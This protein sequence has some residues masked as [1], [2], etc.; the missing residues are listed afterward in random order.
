MTPST[1]LRSARI[2]EIHRALRRAPIVAL[3]GARQCGKTTLARELAGDT[4]QFFDLE[5]STDRQPL[6]AAP[7]RT[8]A[9]LRGLV[10]LDEVQMMPELLPVLPFPG[11]GTRRLLLGDPRRRGAGPAGR[12]WRSALRL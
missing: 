11:G 1:V 3:L 2:A 12:S 10:V 9:A 7:A 5:S 8:L 6:A 4:T